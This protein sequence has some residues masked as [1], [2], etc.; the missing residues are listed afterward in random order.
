ML[1]SSGACADV[2]SEC[3]SQTCERPTDRGWRHLAGVAGGVND[4]LKKILEQAKVDVHYERRVASIDEQQGQW[5]V[6]PMSGSPS[7][8]EAVIVA[9]PGCGIGGDNLNKIH[10]GW[11]RIIS[12]QQN[13][14]LLSVQHDQRWAFALFFPADASKACDAF[15]G[16]RVFEKVVKDP[17][18]HLLCYQSRKTVEVGG[19]APLNGVAIIAHS[20]TEWARKNSRANGRD[21]RLLN[22]VVEQVKQ[23]LGMNRTKLLASKVITWKQSQV[24][25]AVGAQS[26]DGPCMLISHDPPLLLA[27]DYFTESNFVV[28]LL[29]TSYPA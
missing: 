20:T 28:T 22:E 8:F 12:A 13:K 7:T 4:A 11:E 5:R 23:I 18:V 10:G 15:F 14:Q 2:R 25:R 24:T 26:S 27:G 3:L 6:K 1:V 29:L 17:I 16:S 19:P 9:I 21:Q